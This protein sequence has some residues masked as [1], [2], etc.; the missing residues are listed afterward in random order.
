MSEE[1]IKCPECGGYKI[2]DLFLSD[3]ISFLLYVFTLGMIKP[4]KV[5]FKCQIC[6][7]F[8]E[9]PFS[10]DDYPFWWQVLFKKK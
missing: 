8:F 6:G 10:A 7:Y 2:D 1:Q 5:R 9:K 4:K 3:P